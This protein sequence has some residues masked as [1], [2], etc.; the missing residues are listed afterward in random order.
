M[1]DVSTIATKFERDIKNAFP[2]IISRATDKSIR[3]YMV[4]GLIWAAYPKAKIIVVRRDPRD[5]LLSI[6]KNVFP[7]NTHLNSYDLGDIKEQYHMFLEFLEFWK[8]IDPDRYHEVH[9]EDIIANPEPEIFAPSAKSII[10]YFLAK[11]Q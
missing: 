6:Y 7:P 2:D 10:L 3:S 9:Y 8:S 11:S 5:N 4:M 1:S